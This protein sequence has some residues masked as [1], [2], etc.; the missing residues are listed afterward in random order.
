MRRPSRVARPAAEGQPPAKKRLRCFNKE[1]S[2]VFIRPGVLDGWESAESP[3]TALVV[4]GKRMGR[5]LVPGGSPRYVSARPLAGGPQEEWHI[6]QLESSSERL[7]GL[8][9]AFKEAEEPQRE[10]LRGLLE[11][12]IQELQRHA[13]VSIEQVFDQLVPGGVWTEVVRDSL[14]TLGEGGGAR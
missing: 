4:V 2:V 9:R 7:P 1:G 13:T 5:P 3:A 14:S 11:R 6:S 8:Y 12:V 10:K